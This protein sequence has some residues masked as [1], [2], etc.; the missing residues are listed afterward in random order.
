M[1]LSL[2]IPPLNTVFLYTLI[3]MERLTG[4]RKALQILDLFR[5]CIMRGAGLRRPP[6]NWFFSMI[7]WKIWECSLAASCFCDI[8]C[9]LDSC[10]VW[11]LIPSSVSTVHNVCIT[12]KDANK[13]SLEPVTSRKTLS[14]LGFF[15]HQH[16]HHQDH[17][18]SVS[19]TCMN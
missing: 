15:Y 12:L 4:W 3:Y 8:H 19:N 10:A 2:I 11:M 9:L 5:T 13:F 7:L 16:W 6:P 1:H 14:Y 18:R 17:Y